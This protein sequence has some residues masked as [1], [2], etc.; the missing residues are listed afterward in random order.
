M[1]TPCPHDCGGGC[2]I[3]DS[4][5]QTCNEF[6]CAY[7]QGRNVPEALRPDKCGI[8]FFKKTNR[9]F[10]GAIMPGVEVADIAKGQIESFKQQGYSVV[11]LLAGKKPHIMLAD[12]HDADSIMQEYTGALDGNLQY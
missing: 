2:S 12:E 4:K 7:L 11:L 5:P 3:Y 6:E 1:N 9:V 8:V 10:V